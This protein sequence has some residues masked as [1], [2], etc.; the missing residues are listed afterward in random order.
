M[1][2]YSNLKIITQSHMFYTGNVK[3]VSLT[4]KSG[5]RIQISPNRSEYLSTIDICELDIVEY[6]SDKTIFCSISDGIVY[7]DQ[8]SILIITND[9]IFRD[10][11]DIEKAEKDKQFALSKL[12]ENL[13]ADDEK[14]FEIKLKKVI[15]RL[16]VSQD[17]K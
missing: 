4:T 15:N 7:A 9:I 16:N 3:S 6:E 1:E 8:K 11:I 10:D 14:L 13:N 5:G 12:Q 17:H 2:K